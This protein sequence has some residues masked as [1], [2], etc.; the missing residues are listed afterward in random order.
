M[1]TEKSSEE[2]CLQRGE[3]MDLKFRIGFSEVIPD[4]R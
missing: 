1:N 2:T 4:C 3:E